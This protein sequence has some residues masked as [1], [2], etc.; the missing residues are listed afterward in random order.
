MV[1]D[2]IIVII[3]TYDE[4]D[5]VGPISQAVFEALPEANILFV[6]DNSPDGT[7]DL[8]DTLVAADPRIHVL[9]RSEKQGLGRAYIAGFKWAL[10]NGYNRI[11]EMD[12][13]FSHSP[14][15]LPRLVE[16]AKEADLVIGS[17]YI[18]GIRVMN[19]PMSRLMIST[20]AGIYVRMITG[21]QICDPTGGF[22]CFRREVLEALDLDRVTSNG[23]SFQIEL[24]HG[25]WMQGFRLK[26]IPI[27][28]EERRAGYSKMNAGIAGEAFWMVIKLAFRNGLRRWP[29]K[30]AP[31]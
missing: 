11:I 25:A 4:R 22:K 8:I 5:N 26:E 17:R 31:K 12:A 24:N 20:C 14:K 19:W 30:Q 3:P 13:D 16:T 18:G 2:K 6:D 7:G 9:H 27:I 1:T 23:Y 21:M 28:F 29:K 10:D 15:D